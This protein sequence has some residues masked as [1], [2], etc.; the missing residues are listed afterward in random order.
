MRSINAR[1]IFSNFALGALTISALSAISGCVSSQGKRNVEIYDESYGQLIRREI[2]SGTDDFDS[3]QV[4]FFWTRPQNIGT[5]PWP[6][7]IFIHGDQAMQN[8]GGR[9]FV[10]NGLLRVWAEK[11][12][13]TAALSLPGYGSTDGPPDLCGPQSQNTISSTWEWL[14]DQNFVS[15][16][17]LLL[18]GVGR[19]A[20][21][22]ALVAPNIPELKGAILISGFYDWTRSIARLKQSGK[23][24]LYALAEKYESESGGSLDDYK[25]R[26]PIFFAKE[27]K[28][29][30]L[31][32]AG[33]KDNRADPKES[34]SMATQI[35]GHGG[36]A[37]AE[38]SPED[39]QW[40]SISF[41]NQHIEKFLAA[42]GF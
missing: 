23:E 30:L 33:G 34:E 20:T 26:S 42:I 16:E 19:G 3:K 12:F 13:V 41:R 22:A 32:L 25:E 40:V 2:I 27:I 31:L 4:E 17:K 9:D 29:P 37:A 18:W 38:I 35:L 39:G 5:G 14:R 10:R 8:P 1:F 11:G 6:V 21:T 28:V 15:K 7:I 24:D 36:R